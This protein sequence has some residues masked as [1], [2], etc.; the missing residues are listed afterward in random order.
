[1]SENL[2]GWTLAYH[3]GCRAGFRANLPGKLFLGASP[4][5][6]L[7][8]YAE[9]TASHTIFITGFLRHLKRPVVTDK[10][11]FVLEAT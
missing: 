7:A 4:E 8:G 1:M 2:E 3:K 5:A 9:G 11:G 10:E 6:K